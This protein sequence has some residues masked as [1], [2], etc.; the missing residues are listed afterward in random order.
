MCKVV[1]LLCRSAG[2]GNKLGAV[3]VITLSVSFTAYT[4]VTT[5][6]RYPWWIMNEWVRQFVSR[7]IREDLKS[8]RSQINEFWVFFRKCISGQWWSPQVDGEAVPSGRASHGKVPPTDRGPC[9]RHDDRSCHLPT[10][11]E[12]GVHTSAKYDGA[13]PWRYL[14]VIIASL[15]VGLGVSLGGAK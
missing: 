12:T 8:A 13:R 4:R 7:P 11:D 10:T 15:K 5:T 3:I 1:V 6:K 14:K 9:A 2:T